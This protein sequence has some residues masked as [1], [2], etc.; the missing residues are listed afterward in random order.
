MITLVITACPQRIRGYLT[1]WLFEIEPG[2]YVGRVNKRVRDELWF[3]VTDEVKSGK[4]IMTF[5]SRDTESGFEIRVH[6]A[7]W[8][9]VDYD[10]LT[11]IRRPISNQSSS[12][13][14]G[15]SKQS[16]YRKAKRRRG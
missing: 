13:K 12:L 4:A 6:R 9:P 3:T 5:P 7:Q 1:R 14:A 15:W 11:L 2:V 10:G 8:K 16:R